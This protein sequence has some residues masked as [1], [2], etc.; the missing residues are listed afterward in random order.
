MVLVAVDLRLELVDDLLGDVGAEVGRDERGLEVV[1]RRPRRWSSPRRRRG[2]P[3]RAT[4]MRVLPCVQPRAPSLAG[5]PGTPRV[6]HPQGV[7]APGRPREP[8][9]ER[10]EAHDDRRI[11][12][13]ARTTPAQSPARCRAARRAGR[14]RRRDVQRPPRALE[15]PPGPFRIRVE[16]A[17]AALEATQLLARR[18]HR[19][20]AALP[21]GDPSRRRSR[22]S[23]R[24]TPAGSG[25]RSA[26]A[27][28][29]TST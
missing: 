23:R 27:R 2:G 12:R 11:P 1:P 17:R 15:R 10:K 5:A 7:A 21:P 8:E 25:P 16:L 6:L 9:A 20:R 19:A 22:R 26:A 24:C 4:R 14:F 28:R 29:S 18:G 13:L 3:S